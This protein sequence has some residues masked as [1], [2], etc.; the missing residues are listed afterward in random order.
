MARTSKA[1][2]HQQPPLYLKG[3]PYYV[4][5]TDSFLSGWGG[6]TKGKSAKYVVCCDSLAQAEDVRSRAAKAD[7]GMKRISIRTTYPAY[8]S[9]P[10]SYLVRYVSYDHE[11]GRYGFGKTLFKNY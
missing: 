10:S 9:K 4:T 11:G 5:M 7:D 8:E 6:M 2:Q 3:Y 1:Q